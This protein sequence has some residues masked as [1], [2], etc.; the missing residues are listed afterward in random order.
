MSKRITKALKKTVKQGQT[1]TLDLDILCKW[2]MHK[3]IDIL[4]ACGAL[5]DKVE[6]CNDRIKTSSK[7]DLTA[8]DS[9]AKNAMKKFTDHVNNENVESANKIGKMIIDMEQIEKRASKNLTEQN[10]AVDKLK[11]EVK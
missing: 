7:H 9:G 1:N 4:Q 8:M 11:S 5:E 10:K 2:I 3:N 6:R